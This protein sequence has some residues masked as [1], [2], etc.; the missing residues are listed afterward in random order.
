M[1][2]AIGL[3][4]LLAAAGCET[5]ESIPKQPKAEITIQSGECADI[6]GGTICYSNVMRRGDEWKRKGKNKGLRH[7]VEAGGKKESAAVYSLEADGFDNYFIVGERMI[8][9]DECIFYR[10]GL[11]AEK[12]T[13]E[14]LR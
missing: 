3:A 9:A 6:C 1:R 11:D 7:Y 10:K 2:K 4:V 8:F 5:E 13:L 12:L 14:R